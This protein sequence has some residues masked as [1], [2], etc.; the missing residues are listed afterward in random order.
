MTVG[1]RPA[2]CCASF[3]SICGATGDVVRNFNLSRVYLA[4]QVLSLE[5]E[6]AGGHGTASPQDVP[7]ANSVS[8]G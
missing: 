4:V 7:L 5:N 8:A 6:G 3:S 2:L 1:W